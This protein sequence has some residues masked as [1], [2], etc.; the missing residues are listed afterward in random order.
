[1]LS[2]DPAKSNSAEEQ[3]FTYPCKWV[4]TARVQHLKHIHDRQ[5]IYLG[6]LTIGIEDDRWKIT[7]LILK[8]E[9]RVIKS[10]Q[11]A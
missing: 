6:E 2:L 9:E 11:T 5:N 7:R 8:S 1:M 3:A 4:V 10:W